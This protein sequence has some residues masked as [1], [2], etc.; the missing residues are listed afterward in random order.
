MI[1]FFIRRTKIS[2]FDFSRYHLMRW[3]HHI[4]RKHKILQAAKGISF[5][6]GAK[7]NA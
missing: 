6:E 4:D 1:N 7:A 3:Q 5:S 2:A